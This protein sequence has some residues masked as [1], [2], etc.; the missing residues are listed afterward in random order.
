LGF[1]DAEEGG[2]S[3][4]GKVR[5][6][7]EKKARAPRWVSASASPAAR[8][9]RARKGMRALRTGAHAAAQW[10]A[11][12]VGVARWAPRNINGTTRLVAEVFARRAG[13]TADILALGLVGRVVL[14]C[15]CQKGISGKPR[16]VPRGEE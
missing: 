13:R 14:S 7:L 15:A 10:T 11:R 1:C 9:E 4:K 12:G 6:T 5:N 3:E 16:H 8:G 2:W